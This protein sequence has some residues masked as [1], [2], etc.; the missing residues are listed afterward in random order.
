MH[1]RHELDKMERDIAARAESLDRD[2]EKL[3][4][5]RAA[6]SHRWGDT[7]YIPDHREAHVIPGDP[8]GTMGVDW[9]GP[10]HVQ[11]KTIKKWTRQCESCGLVQ[12]T[13]RTKEEYASGK[14]AGTSGRI[15]VPD[16]PEPHQKDRGHFPP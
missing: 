8:P 9:R 16:F 6:C 5:A 12:T 2:R 7:R 15:D 4:S 10:A 11:A 1:D 13:T 3:R 14:V